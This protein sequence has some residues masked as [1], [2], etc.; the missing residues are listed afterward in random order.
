MENEDF[1]IKEIK[2]EQIPVYKTPSNKRDGG[3]ISLLSKKNLPKTL[4]IIIIIFILLAGAAII[5]GRHSFSRAEVQI[6]IEVPEDIAS[7]EE[8][9]LTIKYKN[10]NR[11][12]LYDVYLIIDYPLGTFSPEG[13]E[14]YQEQ[15]NLGTILRKSQGEESFKVRFVGEK[16]DV[17]NLT[18]KLDYRPQNI[19]SRFENGSSL[20]IEIN[21][22]LIGINIEGSEKTIAGQEVKYLIEYE[23]ETE[24][25]ILSLKIELTYS[26]DF[27]FKSA[28]PNPESVEGNNV[29]GVDLL[30][31][32][33]KEAIEL[34]GVLKGGE[35]ES[36]ILK[37]AIGRIENDSFLQYSQSEFV[38]QIAP[39]P[40][41]L[42]LGIEG[43]EEECKINPGQ[44]LNYKIEFRNNTDVVLRELILRANFEDNIFDFKKLEL[45]GIGFFDSR[46]NIITWSGAEVSALNLLEPN[47]LG[48]VRFSVQIKES[49]PIFSFNDKNFQ[50]RILAEIETLSV[51]AK[52]SIPE[53]KVE[54]EL[55]CKINSQLDLKAKVYYYEPEPGIINIGPIPPRVNQL[56]TYTVHWQITNTSNDLKNIKVWATLPQGINWQNYYI[57]KVSGSNINYN[58]R[59][60]E[61]IWEI[62]ELPAGTGV[63]LPVYELIFQIGL[64]PSINQVGQIPTLIKESSI[65]GKDSFT[66][67]TLKDFSPEI[68]T[69]LPHDPKVSSGQGWVKE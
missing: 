47:Q 12:N 24:E 26:D 27:E 18:A 2:Q 68:D 11:V 23:N 52:F 40:I 21:S 53:L 69:T 5:W 67:V 9:V 45:G 3:L 20:R 66:E 22:V 4:L 57:N 39:S 32:G 19:N 33:E 38:T 35:G 54:R 17:K 41:I 49:L 64:R 31:P 7:G 8:V 14:I 44:R 10:N 37:A 36:K 1:Q 13:K 15:K 65:E 59:T 51:P 48:Q 43:V 61:V 25:D 6:D 29:W 63:V 56:T 46:E 58:E 28:N 42:L 60:K 62:S 34:K 50:A 16:G 55:V 30:R